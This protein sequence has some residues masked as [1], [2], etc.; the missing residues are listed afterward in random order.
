MRRLCPSTLNVERRIEFRFRTSLL[1]I[2]GLSYSVRT[3]IFDH[4]PGDMGSLFFITG[5]KKDRRVCQSVIC[6]STFVLTLGE[7][8][9]CFC[10]FWKSSDRS[11]TE[12]HW[13]WWWEGEC[14][15]WM[16][17]FEIEMG[18]LEWRDDDEQGHVLG[19]FLRLAEE[20]DKW[21]MFFEMHQAIK[22]LKSGPNN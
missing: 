3:W 15:T 1:R 16:I 13:R 21:S 19:R 22:L 20:K 17:M 18:L 7:G 8:L 9:T 10:G 6:E 4:R 14:G 2:T 11:L 5:L 12:L